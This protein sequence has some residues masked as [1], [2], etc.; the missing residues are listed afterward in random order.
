MYIQ[1]KVQ[2]KAGEVKF[3]EK[4]DDETYKIKLK[5]APE[6]GKAN[7]ELIKFLSDQLQIPKDKILIIGGHTSPRKLLKI[8]DDTKLPW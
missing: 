6:K 4:M 8:P 1:I 7:E 5:A 2:P 3:V